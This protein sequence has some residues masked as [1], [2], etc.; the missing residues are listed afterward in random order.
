MHGV[1]SAYENPHAIKVCDD[2]ADSL[3]RQQS[4]S[5]K[6]RVRKSGISGQHREN[7]ELRRRDLK[8]GQGSLEAQSVSACRL[9]QQIA[10]MAA[11]ASLAF[12]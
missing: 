8:I 6:I 2:Q 4:Q 3:W 9:S 7:G 11:F 5:R 1:R 12:A 10:Q